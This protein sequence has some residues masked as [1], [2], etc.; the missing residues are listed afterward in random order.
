[1]SKGSSTARRAIAAGYALMLIV[2][3][4]GCLGWRSL[5]EEPAPQITI[6]LDPAFGEA[7]S[8]ALAQLEAMRV[9]EGVPGAT[10]AVA[11]DGVL[12]WSGA[13]GWSDLD[14]MAPITPDSVMRIGSTSKAMTATVLARLHGGGVLSMSDTGGDHI[15]EPLNPEWASM[16]LR[17]LM[18]HTAGM[19]GYEENT[20][21]LGAIDTIRMQGA[22]ESVEDGLR[23]VDGSRLLFEP[24]AD[25][26]YSSFDVNLAALTA[27]YASGRDYAA[28]IE[29][30]VRAPLGLGTPV[31]GDFGPRNKNEARYYRIR[32]GDR[33]KDWPRMNISQRWPGGGLVSRSRDLVLVA[34]AWLDP[35]FI[36]PETREL[37]WTPVRLSDGNVNEQNYAMGWRV[38][39]VS[40]RFGDTREPVVIV[41]H[42]GVGKGAKSWLAHYPEL[43]IAVA[44]NINTRTPEFTDFA[45]VESDILRI[46]AEAAERVPAPVDPGSP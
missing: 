14:A 34:S 46:F 19:P 32:S 3:V 23:L 2:A 7:A 9:E 39:R 10:A 17:Q 30:E 18:S 24:G 26:H 33:V 27:E 45:R 40:S 12:I 5:P 4:P 15:D 38:D 44:V 35:G 42:G 28:L 8:E 6:A 43:G 37:F 21:W 13:T 11:I 20:D 29:D 22:Y 25:F 36:T 31:L 41:H 1:M 16:Q